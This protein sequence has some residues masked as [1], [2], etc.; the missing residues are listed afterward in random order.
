MD[1]NAN[2]EVP[3][4]GNDGVPDEN[5]LVPNPQNPPPPAQDGQNVQN[6][7]IVEGQEEEEDGDDEPAVK[8]PC[9]DLPHV[10]L[11]ADSGKWE[12]PEELAEFFGVNARKHIPDK[13]MLAIMEDYPPPSNLQCV[14]RLDESA[15]KTLKDKNL[16]ATIDSDEDLASIQT[17]IQDI[18]GPLGVA[19]ASVKMWER[20]DPVGV[21]GMALVDQLHKSII[22]VAHALQKVSYMRRVNILSAMGKGS[23]A[24]LTDVRSLL[25]QDK[26]QNI[27]SNNTSGELFSKKFDEETKQEKT[28]RSNFADLFGKKKEPKPKAAANNNNHNGGS[29]KATKRPFSANPLPRGGGYRNDSASSSN[30][31]RR[32]NNNNGRSFN[33]FRRG[34][35]GYQYNNQGNFA[36]SFLCQHAPDS[37][38]ASIFRPRA[39]NDK[40]YFSYHGNQI[41]IGGKN[42][43]I[44]SQLESLNQRQ[45]YFEY[46]Q[47]LGSAGDEHSH[48]IPFTSGYKNEQP[49]GGSHGQGSQEHVG[50]RGY[51]GSHPEN[52][53]VPEQRLCDSKRGGGIPTH[54]KPERVKPLCP[55]PPFQNGGSEGRQKFTSERGL[56]VQ[57]GSKRRLFLSPFEYPLTETG[58]FSVEGNS[59]RV[60]LP[61]VRSRTS[62]QGFYQTNESPHLH[63]EKIGG[64]PGDLSRRPVDYGAVDREI[65]NGA[66]YNYVSLSPP[67]PYHQ[68]KKVGAGT[69]AIHRIPGH[70]SG[71]Q[72]SVFSASG[73]ENPE[74]D[75]KVSRGLRPLR[76]DFAQPLLPYRE[77]KSHS[78]SSLPCSI[79]NQIPATAVHKSASSVHALRDTDTVIPRREVGTKMVA[80]K[81]GAPEGKPNLPS[82]SGNDHLLGCSKVGGMG[83]CLSPG[84]DGRPMDGTGKVLEHKRSRTDSCRTGHKDFHK[85]KETSI[86]TYQNRQHIGLVLHCKDGGHGKLGHAG[87]RQEDLGISFGTPDHDYCGMDSITSKCSSGLGIQ[88]CP[89][90]LRV[91][92]LPQDFPVIMQEDG[93]P[94]SG[95]LCIEGVPPAGKVLQLERGP[96]VLSNGRLPSRLESH[97]PVRFPAILSNQSRAHSSRNATSKQNGLDCTNMADSAVVSTAT[98]HGHRNP[99]I[100]STTP[101]TVVKPCRTKTP[102]VEKLLSEPSGLASVRNRLE[103]EGL[104]EEVIDLMLHSRRQGTTQSYES[105]WKNWR[106]WCGGRGVDPIRCSV[107]DGLEYLKDLFMLGRPYR[108]I[109]LHRSA[110]SAYHTPMVVGNALVPVGKHPM[111]STLMSAVHNLRPPTAKYSF[112]WDIEVVLNMFRSWPE[113]L[114]PKQ[115]SIKTVTLLSL[116]GIPRKAEIHLFDLDYFADFSHYFTFDMPGTVKNIG[117]GGKPDPIE[118]H[119]HPEDSKLCPLACIREYIKLTASWRVHGKPAQFFLTHKKPHNPASR[120]TLA[121]WIKNA[122]LLADV[123]TKVFQAHSLRGASTSQALLKGLSVRDIVSHGRWSRESTWQRF[124]HKKVDSTS[125]RYQD[126]VL[127]L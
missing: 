124:Y 64:V 50:K 24:K 56:D 100:A 16:N 80:R 109:N 44:L 126:A 86:H 21:D 95:H 61:G 115:L 99:I 98:V 14:P 4:R 13:D 123:D 118:F 11:E 104:S 27:F 32:D 63:S 88:E 30:F 107:N 67:R 29:G 38:M 41:S 66:G 65:K 39:S 12:L 93:I 116:I 78:P 73:E 49:R 90:L 19:W 94:G 36:E 18:A 105:A 62:A 79:A 47:G 3:N 15:R 31:I 8:K 113:V 71:Q 122:L 37:N 10:P 48:T 59:L 91:E 119:A 84:V 85:G 33:M 43:E 46:S 92:T 7:A 6:D 45:N 83:S 72:G 111:V 101:R 127:K 17:K 70:H 60:S 22:L 125:K 28:S 35:G 82:P 40:G 9:Y 112:T 1:P 55:I 102:F 89:R 34:G 53:P 87:N 5:P 114:T 20:G 57:N 52:G 81:L 75:F 23:G 121:R 96:R 51:Q 26:I 103:A 74:V 77:T 69:H 58:S 54:H 110:I 42:S 76:N 97:F 106:L 68:P 25:K 117:E 2:V 108:S 120:S